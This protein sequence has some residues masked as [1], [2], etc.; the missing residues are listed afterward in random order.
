MPRPK[1]T[2]TGDT[3]VASKRTRA[4]AKG[5]RRSAFDV[6]QELKAKRDALAATY[7][8]RLARLDERIRRLEERHEQKFRLQELL[9]TKSAEELEREAEEARR[10]A[11]LLR[12][13]LRQIQK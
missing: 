3:K 9:Q 10:R 12:K 13:A 8:E 1:S 6:V 4:I 11:S 5:K 7:N 2:K